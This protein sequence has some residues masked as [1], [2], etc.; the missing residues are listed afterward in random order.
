M[1]F[2]NRGTASGEIPSVSR[3]VFVGGP[4]PA[5][6]APRLARRTTTETA[7]ESR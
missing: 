1:L 6:L 2:V 3:Q 4:V 7:A 5:S